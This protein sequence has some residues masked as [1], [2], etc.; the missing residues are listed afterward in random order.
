MKNMKRIFADILTPIS[1]TAVLLVPAFAASN[2]CDV[3]TNTYIAPSLALCSTH[4]YNIGRT[5][6][7]SDEAERAAMRDVVALKT[8]LM[9]QQMK[10]QYDYLEATIR[11][12]KIQ[13]EKAI[14]TTSLQAAGAADS[15]GSSSSFSSTDKNVILNGAENC[16][17]KQTTVAGLTCLQ[18]NV[19]IILNAVSSGNTSDARRQL[20]KDL[21]VANT[22]GV[23]EQDKTSVANSE[24]CKNLSAKRDVVNNCAYHL[25]IRITRTLEE[26]QRQQSAQQ[27]P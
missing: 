14:L 15:E 18:N 23:Q 12:F 11:R 7:T 19:R 21:S 27:K 4:V 5:E 22:W 6:N 9:T 2:G 1:L 3:E 20:E 24:E 10:Q 26:V 25:N 17:L 8:T 16:L 13:L